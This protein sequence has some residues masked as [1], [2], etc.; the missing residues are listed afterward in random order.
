MFIS[1]REYQGPTVMCLNFGVSYGPSQD[2][3]G[4]AKKYQELNCQESA[5]P[6][7]VPVH[8]STSRYVHK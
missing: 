7:E 5:D 1:I 2:G 6:V 4:I 3:Q 8:T